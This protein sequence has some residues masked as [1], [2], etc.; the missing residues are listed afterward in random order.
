MTTPIVVKIDA[1]GIHA[2]GFDEIYAYVQDQYRSIYGADIDIDAD[3][4]DGQLLAIFSDALND[5]NQS[6]IA[7]FNSFRPGFA[8]GAGLSSIVKING[9]SRHAATSSRVTL[10]LGGTAGVPIQNVR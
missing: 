3:T 6:A 1:S 9:I 8:V 7:A 4:Q 10:I 5:N 2:P